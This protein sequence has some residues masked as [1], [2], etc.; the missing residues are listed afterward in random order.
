MQPSRSS[1][2]LRPILH[3]LVILAMLLSLF[4]L[5]PGSRAAAEPPNVWV[6]LGYGNGVEWTDIHGYHWP[7]DTLVTMT[8]LD[9]TTPATYTRT[10]TV[11]DYGSGDI[12]VIFDTSGI[13]PHAGD[14]VTLTAGATTVTTTVTALRLANVDPWQD[15]VSGTATP[16]STLWLGFDGG[17]NGRWITV[18]GDGSWLADFSKPGLNQGEAIYNFNPG[19][20]LMVQQ[21]NGGGAT[22][23]SEYVPSYTLQVNRKGNEVLALDWLGWAQSTLSIDNDTNPANGVLYSQTKFVDSS[24]GGYCGNPATIFDLQ[25]LFT[26]AAGQ[27]VTMTEGS[28]K[29]TVRIST[30]HIDDVSVIN[31]TLSGEADASSKVKVTITSQ[32]GNERSVPAVPLNG[33]WSVDFKLAGSAG[34]PAT[35]IRP[36]DY[37]YAIQLNPDGSQDGTLEYWNL[38]RLIVQAD[39]DWVK[40]ENWPAGRLVTISVDDPGVGACSLPGQAVEGD[41]RFIFM[42]AS[43]CDLHL[44]ET[45]TVTDGFNTKT[46][47][48]EAAHFDTINEAT[49][50][51]IGRAAA[52]RPAIVYVQTDTSQASLDIT[53]GSTGNWSANFNGLLDIRT[54]LYTYIRVYDPD[55]DALQASLVVPYLQARMDDNEVHGYNWPLGTTVSLTITDPDGPDYGPVSLSPVVDPG[56]ATRT[57]AQ[58]KLSTFTLQPRQL[59][60]MTDGNITKTHT[61]TDLLVTVVD[62]VLDTVAG[63]GTSS[64]L[65]FVGPLCDVGGCALRWAVPSGGAWLAD[66]KAVPG[67]STPEEGY[68]YDIRAGV[69]SEAVQ[70]DIDNDGTQRSWQFPPYWIFL[71]L[72]LR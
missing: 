59:I 20:H 66:F 43:P 42:M 24:C 72:V 63:T 58:F 31:E 46:T 38:P 45:V 14:V 34:N 28:I 35:D 60:S 8:Y 53:I 10:A 18:A 12:E 25:G 15:R 32:N 51:A 67:A 52:G 41:G 4:G 39:H 17:P 9:L 64:D 61:V 21:A 68:P 5:A 70:A 27:F 19:Q 6:F 56:D 29:K 65:I 13:T 26:L 62:P 30:L 23:I 55:G 40:G 36:S 50:T 37:G 44:G 49:N 3:A 22:G 33:S 11:I 7:L 2:T 16:G 47:L 1:T 69:R 57:L 48:I 54:I 71:P